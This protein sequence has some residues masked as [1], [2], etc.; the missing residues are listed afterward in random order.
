MP[1]DAPLHP[2]GPR[3]PLVDRL[4]AV[5]VWLPRETQLAAAY[6]AA[7][8]G[9]PAWLDDVERLAPIAAKVRPHIERVVRVRL[10]E[11]LRR[12]PTESHVESVVN[13]VH[14]AALTVLLRDAPD[15]ED[16]SRAAQAYRGLLAPF[17]GW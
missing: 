16:V 3:G 7:L 9:P 6:T 5:A 8:L 10:I 15:R 4:V 17:D 11:V 1:Q 12:T 13:A 2:L 14:A